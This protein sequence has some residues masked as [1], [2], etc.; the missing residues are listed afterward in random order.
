MLAG[1]ILL[2]APQ[3]L[4]N[5]FQFAFARIFHWPLSIGRNVSL[6]AS[7][8]TAS[9]QQPTSD[10]VSRREY[11]K[12][13]AH[14]DN[15]EEALIQ[16]RREFKKLYGLYNRY[17]WDG[18]EFALA[19]VTRA[20]IDE[21]HCELIINC[22]EKNGLA[23]GQFVL[24]DNTI[25]GAISEVSPHTARVKLITDPTSKIAVKIRGLNIGAVMQGN[26]KNSASVRLL[27]HKIKIG[28]KVRACK[29]PGFLDVP[30][31]TGTVARCETDDE[32]P[33]LWDITVEP[34]CDIE[35]LNSVAV[36][37]MKRQE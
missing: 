11:N 18:V 1:F 10:I 2:F 4:T 32:N 22:G 9:G 36:I 23:R 27:K 15:L 7:R 25:I 30:M 6:F 21:S 37:I 31:I 29:K 35:R 12:L 20:S 19:D 33:L 14:A 13:Q 5:K 3:K 24:G 28:E 26:G 17:V 16:G 34:V 8:L